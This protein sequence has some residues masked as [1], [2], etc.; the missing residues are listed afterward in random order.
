M[1]KS[2]TFCIAAIMYLGVLSFSAN[3]TLID[4]G[5][6]ITDTA[7][8]LDWLKL[9]ETAGRTYDNVSANLGNAQEFSGWQYATKTQFVYLLWNNGIYDQV[10]P[11]IHVLPAQDTGLIHTSSSFTVDD[12][13]HVFGNIDP[14]VNRC[15]ACTR[16]TG[17]LTELDATDGNGDYG[18]SR[19]WS[20]YNNPYED[21]ILS[22][23]L[24]DPVISDYEGY[25]GA[26]TVYGSYLVRP[27]A[28][29]VPGAAWLF[30]SSLLVIAGAVKR[31]LTVI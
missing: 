29:P 2:A 8:N 31:K 26:T 14:Y 13:V 10:Y 20:Y 17:L 23:G 15:L 25:G 1:K 6:Y 3:A 22:Y 4:H 12:F 5:T 24:N 9:T 21:M 27:S 11:G 28:V 18:F 7:S 19:L 16:I 30:G